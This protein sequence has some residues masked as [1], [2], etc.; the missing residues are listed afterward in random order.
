MA[1]DP[2]A[3]IQAV[4]HLRLRRAVDALEAALRD[5]QATADLL[6]QASGLLE[7]G[8]DPRQVRANSD[9]IERLLALTREIEAAG[10]QA[11]PADARRRSRRLQV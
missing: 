1:A 4:R 3:A 10:L 7:R 5:G 6:L 9:D 11:E 8:V 2:Q